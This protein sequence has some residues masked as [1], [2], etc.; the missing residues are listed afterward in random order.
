MQ[1]K[2]KFTVFTPTFNRAYILD[3][4]FSSLKT[5]TFK[6]F[7]WIIVDDG[8]T[9]NTEVL[10]KQFQCDAN[11]PIRYFKVKNG[12][13]HRAINIGVQNANGILFFIVDSDDYLK[14]NALEQIHLAEVSIPQNGPIKFSGVRALR[15]YP[16][17]NVIGEKFSSNR[18]IDLTQ[19]EETKMGITG[20]KCEAFYT[21]VMKKFPFPEFMGENFLTEC[22][23]WDK[24]AASG[25]KNRCINSPIYICDYLPDGLTA[26]VHER[27]KKNPKGTGLYI[28]QS[29]KYG[30]LTGWD[31]RYT[32]RNYYQLHTNEMHI[33]EIANNLHMT[34][35]T[36][37]VYLYYIN[38]RIFF[39]QKWKGLKRRLGIFIKHYF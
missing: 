35:C 29:I 1:Y 39:R 32:I 15:A 14:E 7:E 36:L 33:S 4:L 10:V 22:V 30:K 31:R 38:V 18:F 27:H 16:D 11:F 25:Y 3:K 23:V 6:N 2:Y 12:G 9:D 21:D 19:L 24:I 37:F 5:Q 13:K 26:N 28:Y 20:D 8:S 17:G 34:K